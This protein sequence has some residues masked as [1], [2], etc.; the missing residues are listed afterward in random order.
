MLML[1]TLGDIFLGVEPAQVRAFVAEALAEAAPRYS[2]LVIPC[3]GRFTIAESAYAAKWDMAKLATSDVSLFSSVLGF[4]FAG[5]DMA[6]L[7][8][9]FCGELA[10]MQGLLDGE[11][12]AGAILAGIKIAQFRKETY[13]E[14]IVRDD[15]LARFADFAARIDAQIL[16]M[17]GRLAGLAYDLRDLADVVEEAAQDEN[18]VLFVNPPSARNNAKLCSDGL[19]GWN[20][21]RVAAV[22]RRDSARLI[23]ICMG[24]KA[25]VFMFHGRK[26]DGALG[27]KAVFAFQ[28]LRR[29]DYVLCNRPDEAPFHVVRRKTTK[30]GDPGLERLPDGYEITAK[31]RL[32]FAGITKAAALYYRDLFAH[33][34][35]VTRAERY[36]VAALDGFVLAVFGMF[37]SEVQRGVSGRVYE[38]FGF[39]VPNARYPRL[40]RLFMTAI[41]CKDARDFFQAVSG[42]FR[43]ISYFQTTCISVTPEQKTHR[44]SLK[45]VSRET[46]D[47]GRYKLVYGGAFKSW[48]FGQVIA[49][50]LDRMRNVEEETGRPMGVTRVALGAAEPD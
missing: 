9:K 24:A 50:W 26:L 5:R 2:R 7:K 32:E 14:R 48:G 46:M 36:F 12:A 29:V 13:Y 4:R 35:G 42:A 33:K 8:V 25:L 6:E 15:M 20:S 49:N 38:T 17:K 18:A 27:D 37:F 28:R 3:V 39:T 45:V 1:Q 16:E 22:G 44:G 11:F 40:N 10:P 31:S 34:L 19:I 47:D 23:E 21:S 43:E 30:V 41:I